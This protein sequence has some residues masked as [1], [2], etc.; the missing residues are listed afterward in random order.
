MKN[1]EQRSETLKEGITTEESTDEQARID[2][3]LSFA[4]FNV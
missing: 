2:K 3:K 4:V 1:K